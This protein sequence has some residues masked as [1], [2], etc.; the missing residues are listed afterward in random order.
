[1]PTGVGILNLRGSFAYTSTAEETSSSFTNFASTLLAEKMELYSENGA[2]EILSLVEKTE[3]DL[4]SNNT[5]ISGEITIGGN[6]T[7]TVLN[8]AARLRSQYPDV[9]FQ[10][11]SSDAIDVLE[12]L[13]HGSIDFSIFLEPIDIS[14]YDYIPLPESSR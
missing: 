9:H 1:M 3:Y 12:H 5:Q 13:E 11:Y 6:P 14:E 4:S 10:F 7:M 2:E 8:T